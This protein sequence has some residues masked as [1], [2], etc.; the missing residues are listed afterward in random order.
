MEKKRLSGYP[1]K[2]GWAK[3]VRIMKLTALLIFVLVVEVSA[4]LYSQNSKISVKIENGTLSEIFSKIEELSDYRFFY[5]NEQIRDVERKSVEVT[6][7]NILDL[8]SNLL[9]HTGLSYRLVDR[10]II[11]F[12]KPENS[13]YM[14]NVVQQPRSVSGKVTDSSGAPLPGVTIVVKGTTQGTITDAQGNYT[15]PNTPGNATLQ[16]SFVGLKT[17]EVLVAGRSGINI[18]MEE[19]T[20]G[21]E[22][23]VAIGYGTMKKSD[24]TGSIV[25][26]S[27]EKLEN[28][29]ST[30]ALQTIQGNIAGVT[31]TQGS[32]T[33]G[34]SPSIYIR[35]LNSI[36]ASNT[37]LI[38]IDGIPG[39]LDLVSPN[40]IESI[41]V[42]KDASSSAI[43]GARGANGVILVTTKRGSGKPRVTYNTYYGIKQ[44]TNLMDFMNP[45]KYLYYRQKFA[46]Y[47]GYAFE[48]VDIF[49]NEEYLNYTL[50]ITTDWQDLAFKN[51]VVSEHNISFS[52]G[53]NSLNY[54]LSANYLDHDHIA[55]NYNLKRKSV[56]L[57]VDKEFNNWLKIGNNLQVVEN[58]TSGSTGSIWNVMQLSPYTSPEDPDGNLYIWPLESSTKYLI[59]PLTYENA[60][61]NGSSIQV[62][63]NIYA[64]IKLPFE[65]LKYKISYGYIIDNSRSN[66]YYGID[67][68]EGKDKNRYA[69]K[70]AGFN[71]RWILENVVDYKKT[72]NRHSVYLTG[73]YSA[74]KSKYEE[75]SES[76]YGFLNDILSYNNLSAAS[77]YDPAQ[78]S[79]SQW[80][81]TSLMGRINY[82][83]DEKYMLTLTYRR[84]GY[85]AFGKNNKFGDFPSTAIAWRISEEDFMKRIKLISQLKLRLSWG[86]NGNQAVSAYSSQA[87]VGRNSIPYPFGG[88]TDM[89]YGF[90]PQSIANSSLSWETTTSSNIGVDFGVFNNRINGSVE[91]Y[92]TSTSD[93]LL[94]R[95]IPYTTGFSSIYDNIG[96]TQNDGVEFSLNTINIT[97]PNGFKWT[98]TL[99]FSYNKNE[100][101]DLYGDK[102]DDLGNSWF[103]G[104]PI[105]VYY[106]YAYDG[107]WQESDDIVN[108]HMPSAQP[109]TVRIKDISGPDGVPDGT[110]SADY[111][112]QII[113]SENP[114]L[115]WGFT[116]TF[117]YRGF[118]LSI[119]FQGVQGVTGY[120]DL[121]YQNVRSSYMA[122][123]DVDYWLPENPSNKYPTGIYNRSNT[124]SDLVGYCDASY[125]RLKDITVGYTLPVKVTK[126]IGVDKLR[127]YMNATN[128]FTITEWPL[129]DPETRSSTGP[130][131][132]SF[133]IGLNVSF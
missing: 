107:I 6:D 88:S 118:D 12:P 75:M 41:T 131:T 49:K 33:P 129:F 111:D 101:V 126:G 7:K 119:F 117:Q 45:E 97:H 14:N 96:K 86:K 124:Y 27:N 26:I 10:N 67:T 132:R 17:Q 121:D 127:L 42:L 30:S 16:F 43:Y 103:I 4:S 19:D 73:L 63:E 31:I 105:N 89:V 104:E 108:S 77:N 81:M 68:A 113:G 40:D 44:A 11:I 80:A 54:F 34:A 38:V 74:E 72:F 95:G 110:I 85:S 39:S 29:P 5:Q 90:Y 35:G 99:N 24:V 37:P 15:L 84:D 23:V 13:G 91:Y 62:H 114:D 28:R 94:T 130:M 1:V 2:I 123:L 128:L 53:E 20:L 9:D 93:I 21:I 60:D 120:H 116:N 36:S 106:D 71:S 66:S 64:E 58:G 3:L 78:S 32:S 112:R 109:G 46:E 122:M 25:S 55:G 65:G 133:I 59:N 82:N 125:L 87:K 98:S 48:P 70:S 100:I 56:R 52:G 51:A 57:N 79:A 115:L 50:G 8:V 92:H 47:A 22:E 102:K 76:A 69:K 83:F 61:L 18:N